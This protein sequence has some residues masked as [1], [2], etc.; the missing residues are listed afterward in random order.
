MER[1]ETSGRDGYERNIS[2]RGECVYVSGK[3]VSQ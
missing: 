3:G 2:N 1:K